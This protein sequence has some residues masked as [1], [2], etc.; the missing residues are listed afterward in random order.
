MD[1]DLDFL[2]NLGTRRGTKAK[3]RRSVRLRR[4]SQIHGLEPI[5]DEEQ[6]D[7][8]CTVNNNSQDAEIAAVSTDGVRTMEA[9]QLQASEY[10]SVWMA[11]DS[12]EMAELTMRRNRRKS[13]VHHPMVS[14]VNG[15]ES[16]TKGTL[17]DKPETPDHHMSVELSRTG[18][19]NSPSENNGSRLSDSYIVPQSQS[20]V[21][22]ATSPTEHEETRLHQQNGCSSALNSFSDY[23]PSDNSTAS[24]SPCFE[25]SDYNISH[26]VSTPQQYHKLFGVGVPSNSNSAKGSKG[27]VLSPVDAHTGTTQDLTSTVTPVDKPRKFLS[28]L[29]SNLTPYSPSQPVFKNISPPDYQSPNATFS[30]IYLTPAD[31]VKRSNDD[32]IN[33]DD[34]DVWKT[35]KKAFEKDENVQKTSTSI[36]KSNT[37]KS[38]QKKQARSKSTSSVVP[39]TKSQTSGFLSICRSLAGKLAHAVRNSPDGNQNNEVASQDETFTSIKFEGATSEKLPETVNTENLNVEVAAGNFNIVGFRGETNMLDNVLCEKTG[40]SSSVVTANIQ[41]N[42]DSLC[43]TDKL[44]RPDHDSQLSAVQK[45]QCKKQASMILS[46]ACS[47]QQFSSSTSTFNQTVVSESKSEDVE[48]VTDTNREITSANVDSVNPACSEEAVK[49][50][51]EVCFN[52]IN[53]EPSQEDEVSETALK[54]GQEETE[55][56]PHVSCSPKLNNILESPDAMETTS[57]MSKLSFKKVKTVKAKR[58]GRKSLGLVS[59][60]P[61]RCE[62]SESVN[63]L[64]LNTVSEVD[65]VSTDDGSCQVKKMKF[66][67]CDQAASLT[68]G[69]SCL[70]NDQSSLKTDKTGLALCD[71][72]NAPSESTT[73]EL[74]FASSGAERKKRR[75]RKSIGNTAR[76]AHES[77]ASS[78]VAV[79]VPI[80]SKTGLLGSVMESEGE[81]VLYSTSEDSNPTC[82]ENVGK[83]KGHLFEVDPLSN[84]TSSRMESEST[85]T[86]LENSNDTGNDA[87]SSLSK[88]VAKKRGRQQKTNPLSNDTSSWEESIP[89]CAESKSSSLST[90]NAAK[91][92]GRPRKI[93]LA[94]N[95]NV[96]N[97]CSE[98]IPGNG[99]SELPSLPS[100]NVEKKRGRLRKSMSFIPPSALVEELLDVNSSEMSGNEVQKSSLPQLSSSEPMNDSKST[101]SNISDSQPQVKGNI[102][103][104]TA[105]D[106]KS[107]DE[108]LGIDDH[109]QAPVIAPPPKKRGRPR[110]SVDGQKV[111]KQT[112]EFV[113]S[114][115]TPEDKM[116]DKTENICSHV[117]PKQDSVEDLK[118]IDVNTIV[119]DSL[120]AELEDLE[121]LDRPK[122]KSSRVQ[123][124]RSIEIYRQKKLDS[125][126][127][128]ED[129]P[130][131]PLETES[132]PS[133]TT[134]VLQDVSDS[135]ENT[136]NNEDPKAKVSRKRKLTKTEPTV[137]DIYRNKNFKRPAPKIWETIYEAPSADEQV[138]SKKRYRRSITFDETLLVPPAKTKMRL[139]K[140][141]K[142]GLDPR[143]RRKKI[144]SDLVVKKRL[145]KMEAILEDDD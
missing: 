124:R 106:L 27:I 16:P 48:F 6:T 42:V 117:T 28:D 99:G 113:D 21:M 8:I 128:D 137:E 66:D 39:H 9:Q 15:L 73:N 120:V 46:D 84:D 107:L 81:E 122:R 45:S 5:C 22:D 98:S 69:E 88:N 25:A 37:L 133:T 67:D 60:E 10:G 134:V 140:A 105:E 132:K 135:H 142:N 143:Q 139:R 65:G 141:M 51:L 111:T 89:L 77:S 76:L 136:K 34:E 59:H 63:K 29:T 80:S 70:R 131:S 36:R 115:T 86:C 104:L 23:L 30:P 43:E 144:L 79:D 41:D 72:G 49:E 68:V 74:T 119:K 130:M 96:S 87:S 103:Q 54:T 92:R 78:S 95:D 33:D 82:T 125:C 14:M 121:L 61:A 71:V 53:S 47:S 32:A 116:L 145:A 17:L 90:L 13:L 101:K 114:S 56:V 118:E 19:I 35:C 31:K 38:T 64:S 4:Q 110:K 3:K 24:L 58:M 75:A 7:D 20:P 129:V 102:K 126:S 55:T 1:L 100:V 123:K 83:Q 44:E 138:Y 85:S 50:H 18:D 52:Y 108:Y 11:T 97:K 91:K 112:K 40:S 62:L 127:T 93:C 2:D 94:S 57:S 109:D 26:P 12:P